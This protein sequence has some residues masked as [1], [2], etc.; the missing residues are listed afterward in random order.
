MKKNNNPSTKR[1][2]V[3]LIVLLF[4]ALILGIWQYYGGVKFIPKTLKNTAPISVQTLED[5][6]KE[7]GTIFYPG[8]KS[9][10]ILV[11]R[12]N[13]AKKITFEVTDSTSG[14]INIYAQDLLNRYPEASVTQ[15]EIKKE[16]SLSKKATVL[17]CTRQAGRITVTAWPNANGLTSVEIEKEN[18]F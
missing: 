11:Q 8:T 16:S 13:L 5:K 7:M 17:T 2:L 12:N 9:E 4:I 10:E 3:V 1:L 15:K 6:E 14:V 18:S